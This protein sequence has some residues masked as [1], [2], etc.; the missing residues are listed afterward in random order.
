MIKRFIKT[1]GFLLLIAVVLT[2]GFVVGAEYRDHTDAHSYKLDTTYPTGE[3]GIVKSDYVIGLL[4]Y[5]FSDECESPP[6]I[7]QEVI[8]QAIVRNDGKGFAVTVP[9]QIGMQKCIFSWFVTSDYGKTWSVLSEEIMDTVGDD[10]YVYLDD[11]IIQIKNAGVVNAGCVTTFN[12]KGKSIYSVDAD[13]LLEIGKTEAYLGIGVIK[14]DDAKGT[15]TLA[16][17][18][19]MP[20]SE[21]E[22][23]NCLY[24]AEFDKDMELVNEIFRDQEAIN[25]LITDE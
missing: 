2:V 8:G 4:E 12:E 15:V 22:N 17:Y 19:E 6:A 14:Q 11:T 13:Q 16:V 23:G 21:G 5:A 25:R 7:Y 18:D 3:N 20:D 9:Y 1:V 10:R 24:M